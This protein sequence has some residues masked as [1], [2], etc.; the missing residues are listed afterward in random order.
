M[1]KIGLILSFFI[2]A[3]SSTLQTRQHFIKASEHEN[4]L[5]VLKNLN[6][7]QKNYFQ[8]A[9]YAA[10][11]MI[12]AKYESGVMQKAKIFKEGSQQLDAVI[13]KAPN[14]IEYRFIRY[15]IQKN[16][17][18][19]LGYNGDMTAD[20]DKIKSGLAQ[21]EIPDWYKKHIRAFMKQ[22]DS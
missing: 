11:L 14:N 17:P 9:Y 7:P 10:A 4:S 8:K 15:S 1:I 13:S 6:S 2:W 16:A 12:G 21:S 3:Q 18:G 5:S 19:I 20:A 22:S